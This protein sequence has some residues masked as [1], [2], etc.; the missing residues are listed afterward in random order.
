MSLHQRIDKAIDKLILRAKKAAKKLLRKLKPEKGGLDERTEQEKKVDLDQALVESDRLMEDK[1]T[2]PEMVKSKLPILQSKYR[3]NSL[4]LQKGT[5]NKYYVEGKINPRNKTKGHSLGATSSLFKLAPGSIEEHEGNI[6][7]TSRGEEREIHVIERHGRDVTA[8]YLKARLD[9]VLEIFHR[10]RAQQIIAWENALTGA[11]ARQGRELREPVP[12]QDR[13]QR[14]EQEILTLQW[15]IN[16]ARSIRNDQRD[17]IMQFLREDANRP[18]VPFRATKF[19]KTNLMYEA[20]NT[21]L[22]SNREEIDHRFTDEN[23]NSRAVGTQAG[24]FR[25]QFDKNIGIGYELTQN[26]EVVEIPTLN[27]VAVVLVISDA[28]KRLYKILTAF[29]V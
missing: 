21:A 28:Q 6:I 17:E 8:A 23:G 5:D 4:Q 11:Y 18:D 14:V 29:P 25:Q 27:K 26:M 16:R 15:R 3:L 9:T 2:S 12:N 13:L 1:N 22:E 24:P 19:F 20:I 10:V 7:L